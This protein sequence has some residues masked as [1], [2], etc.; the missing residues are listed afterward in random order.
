MPLAD[1]TDP[2]SV[3]ILA[4]IE[5]EGSPAVESCA[6]ATPIVYT[7]TPMLPH[8]DHTHVPTVKTI[9][10]ETFSVFEFVSEHEPGMRGYDVFAE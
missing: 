7:L 4:A 8:E 1:K 6:V 9:A 3:G 5:A 2:G 10:P